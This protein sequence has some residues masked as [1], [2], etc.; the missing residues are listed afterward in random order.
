[1]RR[2]HRLAVGDLVPLAGLDL[3]QPRWSHPDPLGS[4]FPIRCNWKARRPATICARCAAPDSLSTRFR[5]GP[6]APSGDPAHVLSCIDR[7]MRGN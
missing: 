6:L 3:K 1:M 4:S 7:R 5:R 2:R